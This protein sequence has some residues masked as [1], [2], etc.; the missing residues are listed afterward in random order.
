MAKL[1]DLVKY[2]DLEEVVA[3]VA[4]GTDINE[5]NAGGYTPVI[6]ALVKRRSDVVKYLLQQDGIDPT[7]GGV[8]GYSA[9]H[10]AAMNNDVQAIEAILT[11]AP[12]LVHSV[13]QHGH[14]PLYRALG[15]VYGQADP[16][17][18]K[19][20]KMLLEN[21]ADPYYRNNSS[22]VIETA[23]EI[24]TPQQLIEMLESYPQNRREA[25]ESSN[26]GPTEVDLSGDEDAIGRWITKHLIPS[27]GQAETVQGELMRCVDKLA[28]EA[29]N[30]GN[31]NWDEGFD[32]L[33]EFLRSTLV[34]ESKLPKKMKTQLRKDLKR[35]AQEDEPYTDDDLYDRLTHAVVEYCRLNPELIPKPND[36]TLH[37]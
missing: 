20:V 37:R 6:I 1:H 2:G 17:E 33:L 10:Y 11:R 27:R 25:G 12:G 35:L 8:N 4:S 26:A 16:D 24:D 5:A 7:I 19:S 3:E 36:P 13:D 28:W 22:S 34:D 29:Q 21:G 32:K 31:G 23:K 30:N 18:W 15:E 9:L 14:Q